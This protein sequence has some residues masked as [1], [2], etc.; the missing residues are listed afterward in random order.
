MDTKPSILH[1]VV[2][3]MFALFFMIPTVIITLKIQHTVNI[4]IS[5]SNV[6]YAN[7]HITNK[8]EKAYPLFTKKTR[9]T[10]ESERHVSPRHDPTCEFSDN[11]KHKLGNERQKGKGNRM[12]GHI[13]MAHCAKEN[14][15]D[16]KVSEKLLQPGS[17]T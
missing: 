5:P 1:S 7:T 13:N 14:K 6:I 12:G 4:F 2:S 15:K 16:G 11:G 10:R 9:S 3:I 8:D 17:M